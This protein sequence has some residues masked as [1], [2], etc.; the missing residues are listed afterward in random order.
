MTIHFEK[1]HGAGNDFIIIDNRGSKTSLTA[2]RIEKICKR[3]FGVGADGAIEIKQSVDTDFY[4]HYYNANGKEGTMCGNGG[5]C[6]AVFAYRHNISGPKMKFET[7]DGLHYADIIKENIVQLSMHDVDSIFQKEDHYFID[8]GSPHYI[9]FVNEINEQ[10][11]I[12]EAKKIRRNYREG[13]TNVDYVMEEK[14]H[15]KIRTFERGVEAETLACGT[16]ITAA[17]LALAYRDNLKQGPVNI[18]ALGGYL[19]VYF[20][21]E[22]NIFK[23]IWL[24][25]PAEYVFK[26]QLQL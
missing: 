14:N 12:P 2:T 11:F 19:K 18:E 6:A 8:T 24:E 22:N 13:G 7:I 3:H 4:M 1:Y 15:L 23:N 16:G 10:L 5:R 26:G 21:E 9:K 20:V 17:A 25:G